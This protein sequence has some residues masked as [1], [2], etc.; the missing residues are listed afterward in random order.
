M[1]SGN[2]RGLDFL[3][4]A[5]ETSRRLDIQAEKTELLVAETELLVAETK[6]LKAED[7]RLNAKLNV[8][9]ATSEGYLAL[10]SRF[11]STFR[12][13][14]GEPGPSDSKTILK[15]N[16]HAHEG[17]VLADALLYEN[18]QRKDVRF[19][20]Q[21]YGVPYQEIIERKLNL[22]SPLY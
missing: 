12:R 6:L 10:R 4:L 15:G 16:I 14:V 18:G 2:R 3:A 21:L 9:A 22:S 13:D 11:I 17:D 7:V 19:F 5:Q 8:V 1:A 20:L